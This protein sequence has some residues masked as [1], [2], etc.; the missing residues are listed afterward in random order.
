MASLYDDIISGTFNT[1]GPS[2]TSGWTAPTYQS[3]MMG[4]GQP[5]DRLA[6]G[7][8]A[9]PNPSPG[10]GM[11]P[12]QVAAAQ[13]GVYG[14]PS[15]S[16]MPATASAYAPTGGS[17]SL[18]RPRPGNA[19]T[20][21]DMAAINGQPGVTRVSSAMQPAQQNG[22]LLELLFGQSKNRQ[23]G[24]MGLLGGPQQGGL[25]QLLMGGKKPAMAAQTPRGLTPSQSYAAANA[26]ARDRARA[27]AGKD[28]LY[29]DPNG[30]A[31]Q[32]YGGTGAGSD[33]PF[34]SSGF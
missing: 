21:I 33:H 26:N 24:L 34:F 25:L 9:P 4:R 10:S 2:A 22:G 6:P 12:A 19:P 8:A 17:V 7:Y 31:H 14:S 32:D 18:P 5:S 20:S 28:P 29:S 1:L 3:G 23:G 15:S 27:A 30:G 11:T 13:L 16:G